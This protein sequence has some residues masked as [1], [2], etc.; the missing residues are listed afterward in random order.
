[1]PVADFLHAGLFLTVGGDDTVAA[2]IVVRL[3][4]TEVAAVAQ[5]LLAVYI[6]IVQGLIHIIPDKAAVVLGK[7]LA[8]PD[9]A[10]HTAQGVAH[11][12]HVLTV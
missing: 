3:P 8:K 7:F 1:M 10:F 11:I 12:V 6:G 5:H 4:F 9:V 2:E